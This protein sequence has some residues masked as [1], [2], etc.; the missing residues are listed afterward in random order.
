MFECLAARYPEKPLFGERTVSESATRELKHG[1]RRRTRGILT[2]IRN[3]DFF[4]RDK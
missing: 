1:E 3:T 2:A 4:L